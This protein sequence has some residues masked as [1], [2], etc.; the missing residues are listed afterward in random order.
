VVD[1][2]RSK[3]D[4]STSYLLKESLPFK[5]ITIQLLF[6]LKFFLVHLAT[7]RL[8]SNLGDVLVGQGDRFHIDVNIRKEAVKENEWGFAK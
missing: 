1:W 4:R 8:L 2:Y 7:D 6:C 5:G 3:Q